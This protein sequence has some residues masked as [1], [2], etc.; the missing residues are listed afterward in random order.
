MKRNKIKNIKRIGKI[1]QIKSRLFKKINQVDKT[2]VTL[3]KKIRRHKLANSGG[4]GK[5]SLPTNKNE[6]IKREY[7]NNFMPTN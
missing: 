1:N 2:L 4:K 7:C 6:R 5:M 3:T